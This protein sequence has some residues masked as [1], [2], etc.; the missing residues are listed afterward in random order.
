MRGRSLRPALL[1]ASSLVLGAALPARAEAPTTSVVASGDQDSDGFRRLSQRGGRYA[2]LL[3]SVGFGTG[4]RFNNPYRLRTELGQGGESVSLTPGYFDLGA[5]AAFGPPNGIQTGFALHFSTALAGVTQS[6]LTPSLLAAYRGPSPVLVFA[7]VGTPNLLGPDFNVGGEL[8]AGG[9][10]FLTSGVALTGEVVG[11]LFFGAGT[12]DARSVAYP[13]L[14][15]QLGLLID[16]EV[17]P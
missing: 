4:L 1:A 14:S 3:G 2:R 8:A 7:R 11:D 17:L 13:I 12:R 10:Y 6:V 15:G 9:G 16:Y 5:A